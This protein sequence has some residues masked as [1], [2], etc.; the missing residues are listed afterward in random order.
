MTSYR[1]SSSAAQVEA[2][3]DPPLPES[4]VLLPASPSL[5]PEHHSHR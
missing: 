5:P 1:N 3:S 4:Q 2:P